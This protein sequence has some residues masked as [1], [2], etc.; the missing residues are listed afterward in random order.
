MSSKPW[1]IG[2]KELLDHANKHL[3]EKSSFDYR[4]AMISIDNAVEVA[5]RTYLGLPKRIRGSDGP[6]K[7]ELEAAIGFP[8][9]LDLLESHG[10]NRLVGIELG[11]IEWY[12]RIRNALY[13]DGNGITVEP[14]KVDAYYQIALLLFQNLFDASADPTIENSPE[15]LLGEFIVRWATLENKL[16]FL[17]MKYL[18]KR[19]L[20][21]QYAINFYDELVSKGII[22][23]TNHAEFQ[24]IAIA[25]NAIVH[26]TMT[27]DY[28]RIKP[29]IEILDLL[30]KQLPDV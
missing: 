16:I 13:H 26:T 8:A 21:S 25:R 10:K 5:I 12:H 4:L 28:T 6:A 22:S 30:I 24:E 1:I 29:Y 18:P 15:T 23:P 14:E 11:D 17:A 20:G 3:Q 7:K 27:P 2:P 19:H 9:L